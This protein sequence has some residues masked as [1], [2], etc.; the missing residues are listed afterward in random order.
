V[1]PFSFLI[2]AALLQAPSHPVAQIDSIVRA[3]VSTGVYPGA[4]VVVGTADTVLLAR[5]VG[6]FSW[7]EKSPVPTPDSALYDLASLTKV[8]GTTPAVMRLVDRGTL[9][10]DDPVVKY[11]PEF[12]GQGKDAVTIRH[13]LAHQ[14]GLRAFL[15]L[16]TLAET[17]EQAKQ[18]VLQEP[19]RWPPGSRV[20]YSDLNAMLLG[21]VVESA[22]G[23]PLDAFVAGEVAA[24]L[25]MW[26]THYL[27]AKADRDR[28]VPINIWHGHP[29]AGVV[30]DQNAERLNRVSGHAGLYST[31]LDLARYAQ[32]YLNLGRTSDGA[33]FVASSI[34]TEFITRGRGNRALGWEMNDTTE[35]GS[36][37]S[38]MSANAF[39][40]GGYTGT[41]IWI[42]PDRGLFVV[43]LT[44]RV[45]APRARR[46]I[47]K[48][49]A[50]RGAVADAAVGLVERYCRVM[51]LA[52]DPRPGCT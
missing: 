19:L 43:L 5:G 48:L 10:L 15:P 21:W 26:E 31:G 17:A 12:A 2:G 9:R 23:I 3:G 8:V 27:V 1:N 7:S 30:H 20:Q 35:V 50:I 16:N 42:D 33:A 29:I 39:G 49:R 18:L 37:G 52:N 44:N 34:V 41:S 11:L 45:A 32:M 40:H 6:H 28:A 51:E 22:S 38:L 47:S 46:S 24:P 13:L 14:S 36:A 4:V 25:G